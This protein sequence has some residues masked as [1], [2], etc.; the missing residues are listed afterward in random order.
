M[1]EGL[2]NHFTGLITKKC[3]KGVDYKSECGISD[4]LFKVV[5]CFARNVNP[6]FDCKHREFPT[7]EQIKQW[8]KECEEHFANM[9]I[10]RGA[11]TDAV[12][13]A[14]GVAGRIQCPVCEKGKVNYTVASNGH[15]HAQCTTEGCVNWME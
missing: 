3:A 15:V 7:K 5:P 2:C 11:I 14:K 8:N 13:K 12:G 6:A 4:G 9:L 1:K 10:V